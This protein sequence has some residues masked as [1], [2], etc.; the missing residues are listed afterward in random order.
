MSELI[1]LL[2]CLEGN[3]PFLRNVSLLIRSLMLRFWD[4]WRVPIMTPILNGIA[5]VSIPHLLLS[6]SWRPF[7]LRLYR[8]PLLSKP[9]LLQ[10]KPGRTG[11]IGAALLPGCSRSMAN[12]LRA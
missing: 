5:F 1:A 8:V 7:T 9:Q 4:G 12:G 10:T 6:R 2:A 11:W 3:P